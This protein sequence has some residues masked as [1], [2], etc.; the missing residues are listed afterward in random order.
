MAWFRVW[1]EIKLVFV[2]GACKID[3]LLEWGSQLT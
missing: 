1:V 3:L 2:S